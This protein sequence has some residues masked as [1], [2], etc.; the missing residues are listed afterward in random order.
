MDAFRR[1]QL[2]RTFTL[3]LPGLLLGGLAS[4]LGMGG[5]GWSG[6]T[7]IIVTLGAWAAAFFGPL[8]LSTASGRAAATIHNPSGR[9]TPPKKEY[10]HAEALVA[11]G[12]VQEAI[13]ELEIAIAED[14]SD[15]QP[16][17]RIARLYRDRLGRPEDAA[18]WFRRVLSEKR[19][20]GGTAYLATRELIELYVG[21][22]GQPAKAA[23]LL[24][25]LAEERPG[26]PEGSWAAEELGRVKADMARQEESE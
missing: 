15:P 20:G 23:P 25:R 6:G 3:S 9:T 10:S 22:L 26:T 24:A 14:G 1:T 16:Y 2:I 5:M 12:L 21:P 4:A 17:L 7:A 11:R 18:Q 19:A 13:D 8:M